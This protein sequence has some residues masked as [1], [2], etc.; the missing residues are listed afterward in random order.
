MK[1]YLII[2]LIYGTFG[3]VMSILVGVLKDTK[4]FDLID[5]IGCIIG[6]AVCYLLWPVSL[7]YGGL[8]AIKETK[9]SE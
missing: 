4:D 7:V 3:L 5:W 6:L 2:G 9:E 1:L 8:Q